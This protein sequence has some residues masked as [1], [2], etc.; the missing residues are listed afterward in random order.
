MAK[1]WEERWTL[2]HNEPD[3]CGCQKLDGQTG[4]LL[5]NCDSFMAA[6]FEGDVY[7]CFMTADLE[8]NVIHSNSMWECEMFFLLCTYDDFKYHHLSSKN[9]RTVS[10]SV[11][12]VVSWPFFMSCRTKS[13]GLSLQIFTYII[14]IGIIID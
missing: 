1:M 13:S 8:E 9:S 3:N 2:P 4:M 11:R 5:K 7:D 14:F 6:D 10:F 12:K